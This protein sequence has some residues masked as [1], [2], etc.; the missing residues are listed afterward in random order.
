MK[1]IYIIS[2]KY[3]DSYYPVSAEIIRYTSKYIEVNLPKINKTVRIRKTSVQSPKQISQVRK[4]LKTIQPILAD[5]PDCQTK[6]YLRTNTPLSK[7]QQSFCRCILHV[8]KNKDI[9]SPYGICYNSVRPSTGKV[10]S[11]FPNYNF[12]WILDCQAEEFRTMY[13]DRHYP[14]W[15]FPVSLQNKFKYKSRFQKLTRKDKSQIIM[16]LHELFNI[17]KH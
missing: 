14:V 10:I 16:V 1:S 8:S 7:T 12:E 4:K 17:N 6:Q 5:S 2:G 3:A 13:L 15:I 9:K 11:C